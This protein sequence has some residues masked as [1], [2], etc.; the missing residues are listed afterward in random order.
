MRTLLIVAVLAVVGGA[1]YYFWQ[2]ATTKAAVASEASG[3]V[4]FKVVRGDLNITLAENGTVRAKD[5]EKIRAD[6]DGQAKITSLVE[7][8]KMVAQG[9]VIAQ[10]D[11]TEITEQIE[12]LELDVSSTRADRDA[13]TTDKKIQETENEAN[14]QKNEL[15]LDEKK[16]ELER[17]I[18]GD[19]KQEQRKLQIAIEDAQVQYH[20]A[21]K[22]YDDSVTLHEQEYI[23]KNQL[24]LDEIEMKKAKVQ[25]ESAELD[26]ELW[27]KYTN[28]M[29]LAQKR[30][31]VSDADRE[32]RTG[33]DRGD[34]LLRQKDVRLGQSEKRLR[35][36]EDQ[37]EKR[38]REKGNMTIKAPCPGILLHGDPDRMWMVE[39]IKV[40]G[41]I[42]GRNP[43]LT[44]PDLRVMQVQL[45]IHEADINKIKDGQTAFV[46][47]DT[48]PGLKITG[49]VTKIATI[50]GGRNPWEDSGNE[51][52]K[53]NVDI[54][55]DG[56]ELAIKPGI[57]AK[58]EIQIDVRKS[59]VHVP[60]QAV[61][62]EQGD[63]FCYVLAE[64]KPKRRQVK[65]GLGN[66][67]FVEVTDG[68]G[69]GEVVLLYNPSL[70]EKGGAG[71]ERKPGD[72]PPS[73]P[74]KKD[75]PANPEPA[76][77]T[78]TLSP[79]AAAVPAAAGAGGS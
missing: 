20:L 49:K 45:G 30:T 79:D 2:P 14:K 59:V 21:K 67:Q 38:Q 71:G 50:A 22:K 28:P 10:L 57:S 18:E 47:F 72:T 40:G 77:T 15:A 32:C 26:L 5:S 41:T 61:F 4:V 37:L 36:L 73:E 6:I 7:E 56:Q 33:Q 68:L 24:E 12:R 27:H 54:T 31:A 25:L 76:T 48:Y 46:T 65:T 43:F 8:G 17:Y 70:S 23:T 19:A 63:T 35:S 13:A 16:K 1:A 69:E 44:I 42:W 9:E 34:S 78:T 74:P 75:A 3:D 58:A 29:T 53:F 51:V 64:Q 62:V 11:T 55:L 60:L 39:D 52:K 66:D